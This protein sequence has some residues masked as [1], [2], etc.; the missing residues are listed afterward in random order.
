MQNDPARVHTLKTHLAPFRDIFIHQKRTEARINDRDY[1]VG[2]Y[3]IL[4]EYDEVNKMRTGQH[5]VAKVLHIQSGGCYGI[6]EGYVNM[7]ISVVDIRSR[8]ENIFIPANIC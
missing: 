5:V 6:Q 3:L 8:N 4:E 2:D 1:Q 7:T